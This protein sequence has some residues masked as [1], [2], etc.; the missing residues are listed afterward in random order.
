MVLCQAQEPKEH[1][2]RK[3]KIANQTSI[4]VGLEFEALSEDKEIIYHREVLMQNNTFEKNIIVNP[5]D[6]K[7]WIILSYYEKNESKPFKIEK[8]FIV[9]NESLTIMQELNVE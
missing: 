3:L 8:R 4:I 6:N 5:K 1:K 7:A 9:P 2:Q